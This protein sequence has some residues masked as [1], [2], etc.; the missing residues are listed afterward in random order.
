MKTEKEKMVSGEWYN[1]LDRELTIERKAAKRLLEALNHTLID[2]EEARENIL[3]KLLSK[4]SK[5]LWLEPPFYCDYGF[6]IKVGKNTFINSNVTI[7]DAAEV[8]IGSRVFIGPN[9]QIYTV[10]HPLSYKFRAKNL[11]TAKPITIGD[12]VWIGGG[13]ILCPG[14]TI[15]AGTVIGA[16]SV[17]TKDMPAGIFAAGNPCRFIR[18]LTADS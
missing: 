4:E 15:G 17:V 3:Q 10:N 12:H 13:A 5:K 2:E 14:V 1:P 11:E 9:A 8:R 16:G 7:L 18:E 6:N